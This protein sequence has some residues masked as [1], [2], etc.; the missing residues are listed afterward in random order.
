MK[1]FQILD[2][3]C[4][5]DVTPIHSTLNDTKGRYAPNINFIETPDFVFEGWGYD[6]T[7]TNDARF[8]QPT[9]PEG[10]GYNTETGQFYELNPTI[11][12]TS[13]LTTAQY[14][15][16]ITELEAENASLLF[17]NLTGQTY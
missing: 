2:G 4:Y 10:W 12:T 13:S 8:I 17:E 16:R 5:H 9:P 11:I 3:I 7:K 6:E 15:A 1:V 14:E